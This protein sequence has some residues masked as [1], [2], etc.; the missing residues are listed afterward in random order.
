MS[1]EFT[2]KKMRFHGEGILA[3]SLLF[4][5]AIVEVEG[6]GPLLRTYGIYTFAALTPDEQDALRFAGRED[7]I[8]NPIVPQVK[9]VQA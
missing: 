1:C 3:D 4:F 9:A 2:D 6:F 7:L 8:V 5:D